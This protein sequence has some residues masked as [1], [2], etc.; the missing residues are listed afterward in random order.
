MGFAKVHSGQTRFLAGQIIDIEVDLSKGLHAFS[1]VGLA[2][3]SVEE[4]K[5]RMSA[6]IKNSGFTSPKYKNQKVVISLAPADLQKIGPAFDLA[7]AIGYLLAAG[8]VRFNPARKIFLGEL[9]LNGTLRPISGTL[10]IVTE[11]KRAGFREFFL[12]HEN[13]VEAT[14]VHDV[15]IFGAHSLRDVVL[16]MNGSKKIRPASP[17][18]RTFHT[19]ISSD[20]K[21]EHIHGQHDAKRALE[22][23]VAGEHNIMFIGPPGTGKTMLAKTIHTLLPPL[24]ESETQ[25]VMTIHSVMNTAHHTSSLHGAHEHVR[26]FRSPHH[27]SSYTALVGGG[28]TPRPGE[29]T[30]AHRG[31][32]FLDEFPEFDRRVIESLRQPLEE[33]TVSISRAKDSV[34]F[35][36]HFMLVAAMNPCPCGW[37]G[38]LKKECVCTTKDHARY[39]QKISGPILDR[40][41]LRVPVNDVDMK[42]ISKDHDD[43]SRRSDTSK[44]NEESKSETD[45]VRERIVRARRTQ[46]CRTTHTSS[47]EKTL[48]NATIPADKLTV[49]APIQAH[50]HTELV[51]SV[52][53]LGLSMRAYH[54]VWRVARTIA[55]L[56]DEPLIEKRHILEALQFRGPLG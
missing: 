31:V 15:H 54:R 33:H 26:P 34:T 9:S 39:R 40:I 16:H 2:D 3:K 55:D 45:V 42:H 13:V 19:P 1:I 10:A 7:M 47:H 22:I 32:L 5:D 11:A 14:R 49:L 6:A 52:E 8:D 17:H 23:A 48:S 41:D 53:K 4:A 51:A 29:M 25:E 12:P 18:A 36:A 43:I 30:L 35:P 50:A 27:T 37:K 28:T 24:E 21:L 44:Q 46:Q 20:I 38:S 56:E